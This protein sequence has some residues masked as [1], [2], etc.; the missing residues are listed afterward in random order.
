M[1][2]SS[3]CFLWIILWYVSTSFVIF[4]NPTTRKTSRTSSRWS[5]SKKVW[6]TQKVMKDNRPKGSINSGSFLRK[7]QKKS[8]YRTGNTSFL[9]NFFKNV[10]KFCFLGPVTSILTLLQF[11][12]K[13]AEYF[14]LVFYEFFCTS[15]L[16]NSLTRLK[17]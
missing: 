2:Q 6:A 9:V 7:V 12:Q 11:S 14:H 15:N 8:S 4:F 16:Y 13:C 10:I 1:M 17:R 3:T 5:L